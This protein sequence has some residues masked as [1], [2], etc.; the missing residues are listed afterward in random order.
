M[1]DSGL[2]QTA[3]QTSCDFISVARWSAFYLYLRRGG[4]YRDDVSD[5]TAA[6]E[7]DI[8]VREMSMV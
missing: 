7:W 8:A 4:I 3:G 2:I 6:G 1:T 5:V